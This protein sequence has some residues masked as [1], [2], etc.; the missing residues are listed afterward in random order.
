LSD[1]VAVARTGQQIGIQNDPG[2]RSSRRFAVAGASSD[3]RRPQ[4]GRGFN[5]TLHMRRL[6]VDLTRRLPELHHIDVERVAISFCQARKSVRH[7]IQASLTPLRFERGELVSQRRGRIWTIERVFDSTGREML[8]LL[9]FYLPRFQQRSF[10]EKL[11]TVVHELWH[12]SPQFDGDLRRHPG[13]CYAH[14]HS[15]KQY[16]ATMRQ[17]ARKWL[18]LD[19][20]EEAYD[21]LRHDFAQLE[22]R[23]GAVFGQKLPTPKLIRASSA[24]IDRGASDNKSAARPAK[25]GGQRV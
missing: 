3:G 15:Q 5:F 11:A 23:H 21:F 24:S 9:S 2:L 12:I 18:S 8:Y 22:R 4:H 25:H 10:D 19:P 20:P 16:D 13:R 7:G 14:S 17:L 1:T 6:C